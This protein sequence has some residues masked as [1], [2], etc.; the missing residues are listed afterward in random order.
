MP[1]LLTPALKQQISLPV[2]RLLIL[3]RTTSQLFKLEA[4]R[5]L[6]DGRKRLEERFSSSLGEGSRLPSTEPP[7]PPRSRFVL[8]A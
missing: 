6:E 5:G 4:G 1:S 3:V 2:A 8:L 7:A